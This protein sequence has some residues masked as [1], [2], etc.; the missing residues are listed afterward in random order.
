M[1]SRVDAGTKT[2][3]KKWFANA[4]NW[5]SLHNLELHVKDIAPLLWTVPAITV[6]I[7]ARWSLEHPPIFVRSAH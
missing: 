7:V 2:R 4:F 6:A 3:K 5:R 1:K